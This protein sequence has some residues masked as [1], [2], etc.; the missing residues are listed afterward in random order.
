[1]REDC[2]DVG[3]EK[4]VGRRDAGRAA[5][6]NERVKVRGADRVKARSDNILGTQI[7]MWRETLLMENK[8]EDGLDG[9]KAKGSGSYVATSSHHS[10][11]VWVALS[12]CR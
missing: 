5:T 2:N 3:R 12:R 1:M 10:R 6:E 8:N 7:G 9:K 4:A 11:K